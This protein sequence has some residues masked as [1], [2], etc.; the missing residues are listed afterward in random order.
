MLSEWV[1]AA[2]D[3]QAVA[4]RPRFRASQRHRLDSAARHA[5]VLIMA[6]AVADVVWIVPFHP[7]GAALTITLSVVVGLVGALGLVALRRLHAPPEAT[8]LVALVVVDAATLM[9]AAIRPD[10]GV[11]TTGYLLLLPTVVALMVP[12]STRIHV[13]WLSGQTAAVVAFGLFAPAGPLGPDGRHDLLGLLAV[14][15][16]ISLFGHLTL[17]RAQVGAFVQLERIRAL[18]REAR[19]TQVRLDRL[20]SALESSARTD[21]L[22]G[23]KNRLCLKLDLAV[24]RSRIARH[25][26]SLAY[27]AIDLDRFKGINDTFGHVAGDRVLEAVA[28]AISGAVRPTDGVYRYGG[29]EFVVLVPVDGPAQAMAAAER[30]RSAVEALGLVHPMNTPYGVVTASVGVATID[31]DDLDR[32]DDAW[33]DDADLALYRAKALG[34]DRSVPAA[35]SLNGSHTR[36]RSRSGCRARCGSPSATVANVSG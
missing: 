23:L 21:E 18:N 12:W 27:L 15:T 34:R 30:V 35:V 20:V 13:T 17:V 29:E 22:T 28:G 6:L 26:E 10:I 14:A 36:M 4:A 9:L 2:R 32:D 31:Y 7:D 1:D 5:M 25:D 3:V 11:I 8:I 24:V 33:F 16:S 19:R